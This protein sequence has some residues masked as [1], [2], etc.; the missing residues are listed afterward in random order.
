MV[1]TLNFNDHAPPHFHVSY[2]DCRAVVD[3]KSGTLIMGNL[4]RTAMRMV[5]EWAALHRVEVMEDWDLVRSGKAPFKIAPL[6]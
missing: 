6:E 4:P 2:G 5:E 1:V 3:I